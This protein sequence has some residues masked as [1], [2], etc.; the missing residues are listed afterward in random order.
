LIFSSSQ[1]NQQ[2][3]RHIIRPLSRKD[4]FYSGSIVQ[5]P[6]FQSQKSLTSY[7]QSIL[8]LPKAAGMHDMPDDGYSPQKQKP[9]VCPCFP[10]GTGACKSAMAQMMDFSL[11]KNP[12][13][14][15]IA[16]SNVFGMLGFYIPF[17]FLID[18]AV[19]QGVDKE[20]AALLLSIIGITNT[21][22]RVGSGMLSDL[23]QVNSLF[24]NNMCIL[25]SGLS[26][27]VVPFCTSFYSFVAVALFFGLFVSG[28]V[29]L[30]SIILVDLLGLDNLTNAF[31]LLI[32]FRGTAGIVGA[33]LAGAVFDKFQ[34][35]DVPF[36]LAGG[37]L[38]I[39]ASI[40][41]LVPCVS[42]YAPPK[43]MLEPK[44]PFGGYLEDIPEGAESSSSH[45]S[46][47]YEKCDQVESCL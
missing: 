41:F 15:F 25:L 9:K 43:P 47:E 10:S 20:N 17:V 3:P 6:E 26:V 18:A 8:N 11:M 27:A 37:F 44:T 36:W 5:L 21:I 14:L 16:I 40:S 39:S 33:P 12:V 22:G 24:M 46:E 45:G 13:F 30:T 2:E 28:Y 19:K 38:I 34:T 31:G 32:L 29:S 7:R 4:I 1:K 35:Y 23:P 42:K